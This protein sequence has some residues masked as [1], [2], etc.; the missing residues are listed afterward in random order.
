ML[1]WLIHA[2]VWV[3]SGILTHKVGQMGLFFGMQNFNA[4]SKAL[5]TKTIFLLICL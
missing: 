1:S 3:F 5:L 2:N 4:Y